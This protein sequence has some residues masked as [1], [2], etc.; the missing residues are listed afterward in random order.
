MNLINNL[1]ERYILFIST[2][3]GSD[4]AVLKVA[5][6]KE[7]V[8]MFKPLRLDMFVDKNL[9]MSFNGDGRFNFETFKEKPKYFNNKFTCYAIRQ[10]VALYL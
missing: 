10:S 9:V 7:V 1:F 4:M 6:N 5:A 3:I 8:V 2:E